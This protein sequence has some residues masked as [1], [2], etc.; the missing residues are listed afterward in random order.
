MT[1]LGAFVEAVY[2]VVQLPDDKVHGDELNVPPEP[3]SFHVT[4]PVGVVGELYVSFTLTTNVTEPVDSV[5]GF[6]V[7]VVAVGWI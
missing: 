1:E 2:D 5:V 7:T 4:V 3:P 6:G